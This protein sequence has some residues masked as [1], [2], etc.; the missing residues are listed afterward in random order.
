MYSKPIFDFFLTY[1][2]LQHLPT[3]ILPHRMHRITKIDY[4]WDCRRRVPLLGSKKPDH[5]TQ[6]WVETW[7]TLAQMQGLK[8][9][10][11][12]VVVDEI[13]QSKWMAEEERIVRSMEGVLNRKLERFELKGLPFKSIGCTPHDWVPSP[14]G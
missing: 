11:M 14:Y 8:C 13:G 6:M 4:H 12:E 3:L 1:Y 10:R 9:L 2:C 5:F 7:E